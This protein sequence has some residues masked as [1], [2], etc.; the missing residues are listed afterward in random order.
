MLDLNKVT[1]YSIVFV[2]LFV[3]FHVKAED[4]LHSVFRP[5]IGL[6]MGVM[7]YYGEIQNQQ[8]GFA[9]IVNRYGGILYVNA[10]L[11]NFFNFEFAATYAKIAANERTLTRNLNFESR[12]RMA[13]FS[14]Y[15]NFYPLFKRERGFF[16][17]YIGIGASSFEFLSKTD[18]YSR[19]GEMYY[20]WSDG[21][22]KNLAEND[23]NAANAIDI[24]RDYR[25]ETDLRELDL[26]SLG[27][28]R[29]QSFAFPLTAGIEFHLSP[30]WDFRLSMAYSLTLTDLI[31]NITSA[32]TGVR[33][34]DPNKDRFVFTYFSLSYDLQFGKK[35]DE[36][37][38][39]EDDIPLFA[40]WDQ[41]DSDKDGIIDALDKCA[42]T[43]LAATV[44]SLGCAEDRDKDGVPDFRDD[45]PNTPEGNF[46]DKFGVTQ[47]EEQIA[48]HWELY[49]DS[50][51]Y[52]HDFVELRTLVT[53]GE[54]DI[55]EGDN[56][57]MEGRNYVIIIGSEHKDVQANE[58][59]QYLGFTDYKIITRGDT[60]YYVIGQYEKIED[61]VA[62]M[63]GLENSGVPVQVISR[64]NVENGSM[65]PLD[66]KVI[67]KVEDINANDGKLIPEFGTD[68]KVF[69]VQIGAFKNK[70]DLKKSSI[71]R[72]PDLVYGTGADGLIR[73]YSGN[74]RT[75]EEAEAHR[76]KLGPKFKHSFVVAYVGEERKLLNEVV[77]KNSL[78]DSYNPDKE[79][80]EMVDA[81]HSSKIDMTR[82]KYHIKLASAPAGSNLPIDL[83]DAL[84]AV[85]G[86]KPVK[87]FDGT[88]NYYSKAF[89]SA[90]ER[91]EAIKE[92]KIYEFDIN[93]PML[94]YDG[95]YYSPKQ[96]KEFLKH[97]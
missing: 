69:R 76:K 24:E 65:T 20:Y 73:Y 61:A 6:G 18:L 96:W 63:T 10:P 84:Q 77:D 88:T 72:A 52:A 83:I 2:F 56:T 94:N 48:R 4:T 25:Y 95:K 51:G 71:G 67:T 11:T 86:V 31:D 13:S 97:N 3:T 64:D 33:K 27:K 14:L 82:V 91:D 7:T 87:A 36:D 42:G 44:D 79:R 93:E 54:D 38:L 16:H 12:I 46:V 40:G 62:A 37:G 68:S 75:Y 74:F 78:R 43:P 19:H 70:I 21:S 89:N 92:Y 15:Y 47:T 85:P 1:K 50:T 39:G 60:N 34:G 35:G 23:I 81:G 58:L 17:P 9:P 5:R 55:T 66:E 26:D 90:S 49:N 28:Y 59:H 53:F 22:I 80:D 57:V 8:K 41:N 29:E 45:E 30:R 32:G